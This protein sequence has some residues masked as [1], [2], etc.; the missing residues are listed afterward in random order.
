MSF[1]SVSLVCWWFPRSRILPQEPPF[2][3][4]DLAENCKQ[5]TF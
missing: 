5:T 4:K 1:Y 2:H 3:G